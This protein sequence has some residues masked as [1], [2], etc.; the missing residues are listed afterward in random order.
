[1]HG[2]G[3]HD[4]QRYVPTAELAAWRL[5][6][7]LARWREDA[8]ALVGWDEDDQRSMESRISDE[9][10]AAVA[11]ALAAPYPSVEGLWTGVF[12]A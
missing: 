12:A 9:V 7:P 4:D 3:A 2:H 10:A 5:R 8:A 1:M 11:A 6:D